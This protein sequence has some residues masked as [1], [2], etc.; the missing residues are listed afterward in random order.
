MGPNGLH[1]KL[2]YQDVMVYEGW[3]DFKFTLV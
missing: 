3:I 2:I 1:S